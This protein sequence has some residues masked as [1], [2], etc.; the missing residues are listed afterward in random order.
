MPKEAGLPLGANSYR[1]FTLVVHYSNPNPAPLPPGTP[2]TVDSSGIVLYLTQQA[3][4]AYDAAVLKLGTYTG[5]PAGTADGAALATRSVCPAQC[6]ASLL[7]GLTVP[8]KMFATF[9]RMPASGVSVQTR[10][11]RVLD[12]GTE[13]EIQPAGVRSYWNSSFQWSMTV[14]PQ[15]RF[16]LAN[17]SLVTECNMAYAASDVAFQLRDYCQAL[18]MYFPATNFTDCGTYDGPGGQAATVQAC[19]AASVMATAMTPP[20]DTSGSAANAAAAVAMQLNAALAAGAILTDSSAGW[21]LP[22]TSLYFEPCQQYHAPAIIPQTAAAVGTI[23]GVTISLVAFAY[24][25]WARY[26]RYDDPERQQLMEEM[27]TAMHAD[28]LEDEQDHQVFLPSNGTA[29]G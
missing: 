10:H 13:T 26:A 27:R 14:L 21:S 22:N 28:S 19:G 12:N 17:D 15:S 23:V 2:P 29:R 6:T 1:Y 16:L 5:V 7:G 18:V 8:L 3:V 11:T 4:R 9:F 25:L 24:F 20:S